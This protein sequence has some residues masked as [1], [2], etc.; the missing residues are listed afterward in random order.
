M[1]NTKRI[2]TF[3]VSILLV[4][5]VFAMTACDNS[6]GT[7]STPATSS[8]KGSQS[9][10]SPTPGHVCEHVCGVCG[11]CQ[12]ESCEDESCKEKCSCKKGLHERKIGAKIGSFIAADGTTEYLIVYNGASSNAQTAAGFIASN[13]N[14]AVGTD[15]VKT[16]RFNAEKHVYDSDKKY[17]SVGATAL[18]E[19]AGLAMPAGVDLSG[20]G[21]YV[22]TAGKSVFIEVGDEAGYQ[23]AAIALLEE[24]IGYDMMNYNGY[25]VYEKAESGSEVALFETEI[26]EKPDFAYRVIPSSTIIKST[27]RYG[28]G[29][30]YSNVFI[31]KNF[32]EYHNTF[33]YL[34]PNVYYNE[35]PEWYGPTVDASMTKD[36]LNNGQLCYTAH[37]RT[38]D[39]AGN[40]T[41]S[42]GEMLKT[43]TDSMIVEIQKSHNSATNN[44]AFTAQDSSDWCNCAACKAEQDEYGANSANCIIFCNDL[45]KMLNAKLKEMGID[46]E[47]TV[48]F[49]S[50]L[51]TVAAPTKQNADGTYSPISEKVRCSKNV[52]VI[53]CPIQANFYNPIDANINKSYAEQMKKWAAVCENVAVWLYEVHFENFFYPYCSWQTIADN[54][55]FCFENNAVYFF[56]QDQFNISSPL[57]FTDLKYYLNAKLSFN[58]NYN[59]LEYT[60]KYFKNTYGAA[61]DTMY[62]LFREVQIHYEELHRDYPTIVDG[63]L[64]EKIANKRF[65]PKALV[66]HW[67]G[68]IDKAYEEIAVYAETDPEL[69]KE[70]YDKINLESLPYRYMLCSLHDKEYTAEEIYDL[71]TAFKADCEYFKIDRSKEAVADLESIYKEWGII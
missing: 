21:Y 22:K 27:A 29:Y 32:R 65:W 70:I 20:A 2:L 60:K 3:L 71:R 43:V 17:V 25:T 57:G 42:Y 19:S 58:C 4:F 66:E 62:R 40:P 50:Y 5:S 37:G 36:T 33:G 13:I 1:K 49:F 54:A 35:H 8:D 24:L 53:Y 23:M 39:E 16:E 48:Y 7:D 12:D 46:R 59:Q 45:E 44:I 41:G 61:S 18:F 34:P 28:M 63:T 26:I 30:T 56:N 10:S 6:A 47:M 9:E 64:K 14:S 15:C 55:R 51:T 11:L 31:Q 67:L 38:Y 69:Y 52:G 68:L